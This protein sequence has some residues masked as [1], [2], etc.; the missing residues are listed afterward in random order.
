MRQGV[1]HPGYSVAECPSL[2]GCVSQGRSSD[3]AF[4]DIRE[5]TDSDVTLLNDEGLPV[6]VEPRAFLIA[7]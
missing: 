3:Q 5:A 6:P 7:R 2:P 1:N 4:Q